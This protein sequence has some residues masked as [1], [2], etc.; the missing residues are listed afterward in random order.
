MNHRGI[1]K[2]KL[3]KFFPWQEHAF[4]IVCSLYFL[5]LSLSVMSFTCFSEDLPACRLKLPRFPINVSSY[6]TLK[7]RRNSTI[8]CSFSPRLFIAA[9]VVASMFILLRTLEKLIRIFH[10]LK[11]IFHHRGKFANFY[12]YIFVFVSRSD[13][14]IDLK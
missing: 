5:L 10:T 11:I 12:K 8:F 3:M 14:E 9:N 4:G 2:L 7:R 6:P 1:V 13:T